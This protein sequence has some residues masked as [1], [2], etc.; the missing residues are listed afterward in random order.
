MNE[1]KKWFTK[2]IALQ[3]K[4]LLGNNMQAYSLIY[5]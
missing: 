3:R 1:L 4:E 2:E 5:E